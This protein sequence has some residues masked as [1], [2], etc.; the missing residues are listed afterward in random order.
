MMKPGRN[1][2][3]MLTVFAVIV[4]G[5][6]VSACNNG[7]KAATDT[8]GAMGSGT[9]AATMAGPPPDKGMKGQPGK[10]KP[11]TRNYLLSVGWGDNLP[12]SQVV[13]QA[14]YFHYKKDSA[15]IRI[16]PNV[17]AEN[18]D[19]G[20][21]M[22]NGGDGHFVAKIYNLEN[23]PVQPLGLKGLETG[24][25][26]VGELD[27][28]TRGIGIATVKNDGETA[29]TR[30]FSSYAFCGDP[31]TYPK[32]ELTDGHKCSGT[33]SVKKVSMN[34]Q[35]I[36]ASLQPR[37]D[38]SPNPGTGMWISCSGGCCELQSLQ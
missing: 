38:S 2:T 13:T 20:A 10:N 35:Y 33:P 19:W 24:Y 22:Q 3:L 8:T 1:K 4:A 9:A 30:K 6:A 32:V 28:G 17:D 5:F 23:T 12:D 29:F 36:L 7:S 37:G 21:A 26:W 27:D 15:L 18:I 25:V 14:Q 16:V 34:A 31:H 11:E